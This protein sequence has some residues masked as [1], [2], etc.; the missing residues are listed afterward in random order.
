M[1]EENVID[2]L[3]AQQTEYYSTVWKTMGSLMIAI[4]WVI[5]S[6]ET[7]NFLCGEPIVRWGAIIVTCTMLLLHF[8]SLKKLFDASSRI[9]RA[10]SFSDE[11]SL[12]VAS[13]YE[14]KFIYVIASFIINGLLFCL[15]VI[16][17]L[18]TA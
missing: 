7:R 1:E 13:S 14:I 4:G 6:D 10:Y 9:W 8:F 5:S 15:L 11:L 18:N 3:K 16:T 2:A 12:A 17:L